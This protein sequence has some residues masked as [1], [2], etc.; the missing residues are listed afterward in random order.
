M[1]Y[2]STFKKK[3]MPLAT[4]WM[5]LKDSMLS[6]IRYRYRT[7]ERKKKNRHVLSYMWNL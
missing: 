1:A 6:E 3:I 4:T 5:N 2:H 7:K